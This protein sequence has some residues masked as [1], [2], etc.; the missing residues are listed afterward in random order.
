MPHIRNIAAVIFDMD[1]TLVDSELLTAP[2]ISA[3]CREA[4]VDEVRFEFAEYQGVS[5]ADIAQRIVD[6]HRQLTDVSEIARR[7]HELFHRACVE[8]PPTPVPGARDA[9][10]AAHARMPTAIVSASFRASVDLTIRHMQLAGHVSYYAGAEDY[11]RSKPAPDGFLRAAGALGVA[12]ER[13]LV[14]ED[15]LAGIQSAK[16]AGMPVVAITHRGNVAERATGLAD[17]AVN[18]FTALQDDFF[19]RIRDVGRGR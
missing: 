12:P 5:W 13:C 8:H 10:L 9:V 3:F 15:S 6:R 19:D 7:L 2:T 18:D 14:F 17:R 1:G 4:G 16:A 11:A